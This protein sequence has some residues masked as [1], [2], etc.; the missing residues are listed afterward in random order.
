VSSSAVRRE[1]GCEFV[2]PLAPAAGGDHLAPSAARART[3]ARPMPLVAPVT[4]IARFSNRIALP[5]SVVER[6]FAA[7]RLAPP[8]RRGREPRCRRTAPETLTLPPRFVIHAALA[9]PAPASRSGPRGARISRV[10]AHAYHGT[11]HAARRAGR[12]LLDL[13][14]WD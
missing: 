12:Y 1:L 2:E 11:V 4:S 10:A 7:R 8:V 5:P 14:V 9:S 6:G 13:A 3:H